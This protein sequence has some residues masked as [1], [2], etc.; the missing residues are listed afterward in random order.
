LSYWDAE[1]VGG[2]SFVGVVAGFVG[3]PEYKNRLTGLWCNIIDEPEMDIFD[4]PDEPEF[5][6]AYRRMDE[7]GQTVLGSFGNVN[8]DELRFSALD[9]WPDRQFLLAI[10][11]DVVESSC[12]SFLGRAPYPDQV[13]FVRAPYLSS[14]LEVAWVDIRARLEDE[15]PQSWSG[16]GGL[17]RLN[18]TLSGPALPIVD[19]ILADH[20]AMIDV[21]T[22]GAFPYPMPDPLPEAVCLADPGGIDDS[23]LGLEVTVDMDI[24][25]VVAGATPSGTFTV[26][27]TG[28]DTYT[29]AWGAEVTGV[30]GNG[31]VSTSV[32]R[33]STVDPLSIGVIGPGQSTSGVLR[34]G[35]E[36]C[37]PTVGHRLPSGDYPIWG[38]ISVWDGDE[39]DGSLLV[40][41]HYVRLPADTITLTD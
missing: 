16:K 14:E 35:T 8:F 33:G 13:A 15:H 40:P 26:S 27:N 1:L 10:H 36:S 22:V 17:L 18:L 37:D 28:T 31:P 12:L 3:S 41:D 11:T 25:T 7:N 30:L 34:I 29:I 9:W 5:D 21:L 32:F 20:G 39:F 4:G 24:A 6:D 38:T 19:E 2:A 23:T